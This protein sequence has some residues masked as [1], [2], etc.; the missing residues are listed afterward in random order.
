MRNFT[1]TILAVLLYTTCN[2]QA[3]KEWS[4]GLKAGANYSTISNI[5]FDLASYK[6][7]FHVGGVAS[8][9]INDRF[10]VVSELTFSRQG[11]EQ[12]PIEVRET[13]GDLPVVFTIVEH[14]DYNRPIQ[15]Y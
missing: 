5:P 8:L 10:S 9:G 11:W 12:A 6:F 13:P 15:V 3:Q 2:A 4:F 7:G 1:I 14:Y